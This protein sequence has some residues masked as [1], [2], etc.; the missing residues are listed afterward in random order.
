MATETATLPEVE[1]FSDLSVLVVEDD[2]ILRLSLED[3]LHLEGIPA[4][5][6]GDDQSL[7]TTRGTSI[8]ARVVPPCAPTWAKPG[9]SPSK[10]SVMT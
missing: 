3:R 7:A 1:N 6:V 5:A 2:E 8:S 9:G 4:R 10:R